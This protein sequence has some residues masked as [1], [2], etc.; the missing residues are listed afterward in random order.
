MEPQTKPALLG[1]TKDCHFYQEHRQKKV[2]VAVGR[3][4]N[5]KEKVMDETMLF[6]YVVEMWWD[7]SWRV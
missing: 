6:F 7:A 5:T 2:T 4:I 3:E 1:I